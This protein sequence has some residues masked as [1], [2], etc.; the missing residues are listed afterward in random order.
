MFC[1]FVQKREVKLDPITDI[2]R[3]LRVTAFGQHRLE[4]AAPWGL[5]GGRIP[6]NGPAFRQEDLATSSTN[7]A[8]SCRLGRNQPSVALCLTVL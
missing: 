5:I 8:R 2:F 1:L 4:V 6:K 3:T 7:S